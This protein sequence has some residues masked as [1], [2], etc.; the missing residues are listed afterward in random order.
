MT[1]LQS[2]GIGFQRRLGA[3]VRQVIVAATPDGD[4]LVLLPKAPRPPK[5]DL[6]S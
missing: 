2:A 6:G 4:D 3:E 1:A 5:S